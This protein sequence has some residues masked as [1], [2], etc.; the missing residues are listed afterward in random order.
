M[1]KSN[2]VLED[3]QYRGLKIIQQKDGYRFTTDAVLLANFVKNASNKKIVELGSGS[4]VISIL[5]AAKQNPQS[6]CAVEIQPDMCDMSK[7][8]IAL[9]GLSDK[10]NVILTDIKG[11]H[12]LIGNCFDIVVVNPPYRKIGSGQRQDTDKIS[13]CRHEVL[14]TLCDVFMQ[15]EKLLKYGGSLYIVH[16]FERLADACTLGRQFNL[17]AKE[18]CLVFPKKDA[19]PN[20]FLMRCAKNG[21]AGIKWLNP[22]VVFDE[23]GNYTV[24]VKKLYG[25]SYNK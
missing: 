10:I 19:A 11:C 18:I 25:E 21:K 15:A 12:T 2:E 8:S 23:Q 17:E 4:G 20:L 14:L 7:R 6:I 13:I 5:I 16:Q 24:T 3:L 22:I 1:L 9:N